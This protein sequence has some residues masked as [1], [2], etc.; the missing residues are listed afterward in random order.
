MFVEDTVVIFGELA[1][2]T[3]PGAASRRGEVETTATA[4]DPLVAE[5]GLEISRIEEPGH[6]DGGDVLKVGRTAYVGLTSRTDR[7][8]IDQLRALLEP[9][10][11]QVVAV[12]VSKVL[13][14]KSG[15][16]ALPDE[17]VIG[18]GPLV[19]DPTV[20]PR[21]LPVPEAHGTAVVDLGGGAILMSSDAPRTA[22]LY[23]GRGLDVVRVEISEFEKLEGCVTCLSVRLRR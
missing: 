19:D 5:L 3:S 9:R 1:V 16:T 23:A 8:G 12:P 15:V 14:L 22:G 10:G 17:T 7:T 20:Y 13:H 18:Y 11:W 21:F 2:L 4:L 6:L